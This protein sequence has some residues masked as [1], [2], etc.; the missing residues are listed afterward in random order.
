MGSEAMLRSYKV[1]AKCADLGLRTLNI[2]QNTT[3][4]YI[5]QQSDMLATCSMMLSTIHTSFG[6]SFAVFYLE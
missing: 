5:K 3:F 2:D 4:T 1:M 6:S